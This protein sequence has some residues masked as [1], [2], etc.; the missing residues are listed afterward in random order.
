MSGN[1]TLLSMYQNTID[2]ERLAEA[3]NFYNMYCND[4]ILHPD[5]KGNYLIITTPEYESEAYMYAQHKENLG[6]EASTYIFESNYLDATFIRHYLKSLY[7]YEN[8]RPRFLLIIGNGDSLSIPYSSDNISNLPPSDI[9]YSC[10]ENY[11][12]E[13]E[14]T[15]TP[16]VFVGR[17]PVNNHTELQNLISKSIH[18]DLTIPEQRSVLLFSG[19]GDT[20]YLRFSEAN[21]Y[22]KEMIDNEVSN[23]ICT[24]YDGAEGYHE[25]HVIEEFDEDLLMFIYR[26]HG[27][28]NS[29]GPPLN[30]ISSFNLPNKLPDFTYSFACSTGYPHGLGNYWINVGNKSCSF[31]GASNLTYRSSNN[32]LEKSIMNGFKDCKNYTIGELTYKGVANFILAGGSNSDVL[33]YIVYGDPSLYIYGMDFLGSPVQYIVRKDEIENKTT[34]SSQYFYTIYSSIGI[35][36]KS[37]NFETIEQL[38]IN[39]LPSGVYILLVEDKE[40]HVIYNEKFYVNK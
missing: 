15:L 17:W 24:H 26:G 37:G 39:S 38:E 8:M 2:N 18:Y 4:I 12:I 7:D 6:Y 36:I 34:N 1:E 9:Y 33:P 3:T 11:N 32:K 20:D 14:T 22:V 5:Y 27:N 16:D 13:N 35:K 21:N 30:E 25:S 40:H 29:F 31:Y 10:L 28:V 19:T 23:V